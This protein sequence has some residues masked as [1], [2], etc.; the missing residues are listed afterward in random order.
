MFAA[1]KINN[2]NRH[3]K[4]TLAPPPGVGPIRHAAVLAV[5]CSAFFSGGFVNFKLMPP[6]DGQLDAPNFKLMPP[7]EGQLDAPNFKLKRHVTASWMLQ[8]SNSCAM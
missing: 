2:G 7:R 8:T 6:C 3:L 1:I 5:L 4:T